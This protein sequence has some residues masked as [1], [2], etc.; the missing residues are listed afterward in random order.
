MKEIAVPIKNLAPIE[1]PIWFREDKIDDLVAMIQ[2][3]GPLPIVIGI[4]YKKRIILPDGHTRT[5]ITA[6]LGSETQNIRLLE[7]EE[8]RIKYGRGAILS[9]ESIKDFIAEYVSTIFQ[10]MSKAKI[11]SVY[12]YP[13][14]Q[15]RE[16]ILKRAGIK[17]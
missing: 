13:I 10:E 14:L 4:P 16:E 2:R 5:I 3:E 11:F 1:N 15:Y 6:I 12:D 8:D 9:S 17:Q 7:T